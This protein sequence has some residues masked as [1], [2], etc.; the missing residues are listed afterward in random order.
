MIVPSVSTLMEKV[1]QF[2]KSFERDRKYLLLANEFSYS[3]DFGIT[4]AAAF[5]NLS[6]IADF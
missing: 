4:V 3:S 5:K 6:Q 2:D 1:A